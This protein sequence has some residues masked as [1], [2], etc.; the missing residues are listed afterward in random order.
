MSADILK[1]DPRGRIT[2]GSAIRKNGVEP[3]KLWRIGFGTYG[4][5]I[6]TPLSI[7]EVA[8]DLAA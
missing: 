1:L 4:T 6:L 3:A 7:V 5:I 2:I 8:P